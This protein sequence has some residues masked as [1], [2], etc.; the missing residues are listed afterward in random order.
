MAC[1]SG[2]ARGWGGGRRRSRPTRRGQPTAVTQFSDPSP[3]T[4][5]RVKL[6]TRPADPAPRRHA[7]GAP[8]RARGAADAPRR[9]TVGRG[10]GAD[11]TAVGVRVPSS[12]PPRPSTDAH[13]PHR[14]EARH[15][16]RPPPGVDEGHERAVGATAHRS[17][18]Q[19]TVRGS[20]SMYQ[21]EQSHI[22]AEGD[23]K[24]DE[25]QRIDSAVPTYGCATAA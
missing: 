23:G 6:V 5:D 10:G 21:P 2:R 9:A 7:G 22:K 25:R 1:V 20:S 11:A 4:V 24:Q 8:R 19:K 17:Y 12:P 16:A 15:M 13:T 14:H 18:S 3:L